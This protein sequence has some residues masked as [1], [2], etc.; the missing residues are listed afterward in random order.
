M[1]RI[2]HTIPGNVDGTPPSSEEQPLLTAVERISRY[3]DP[4]LLDEEL[5][6]R[7][8]I[9]LLHRDFPARRLNW[10]KGRDQYMAAM[11]VR[12]LISEGHL[13]LH[14]KWNSGYSD[15]TTFGG[16]YLAT[17]RWRPDL[18]AHALEIVNLK[19]EGILKSEMCLEDPDNVDLE[20]GKTCCVLSTDSVSKIYCLANGDLIQKIDWEGEGQRYCHKNLRHVVED[21]MVIRQDSQFEI[22]DL[23]TAEQVAVLDGGSTDKVEWENA[24]IVGDE[25]FIFQRTSKPGAEGRVYGS[26]VVRWA[27]NEVDAKQ[28]VHATGCNFQQCVSGYL[29]GAC[30]NTVS[31][32][33][34]DTGAL[35]EIEIPGH[36]I[37]KISP[38]EKQESL[39]IE[40]WDYPS[41]SDEIWEIDLSSLERS[42]P[43][44]YQEWTPPSNLVQV[45]HSLV[46][47]RQHSDEDEGVLEVWGLNS[48][49]VTSLLAAEDLP[50]SHVYGVQDLGDRIV[51][52][53][54]D[55]IFVF[56]GD[57][58][59]GGCLSSCT[60]L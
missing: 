52:Y 51:A 34:I 27:V 43:I 56:V 11:R 13:Q 50:H 1:N 10:Q 4:N 42:G 16:H 39:I 8:W 35:E 53:V 5:T 60:L 23:K 30:G 57:P 17:I 26:N 41:Q 6:D 2:E 24:Q 47:V 49:G 3:I 20:G 21:F 46:T 36:W 32:V 54:D 14:T 9:Q 45:G 59:Q 31:L 29:V 15:L 33:N 40:A 22:W 48:K 7:E 12:D 37:R 18:R 44:K 58:M 19:K 55:K 25:M 38:G 28:F